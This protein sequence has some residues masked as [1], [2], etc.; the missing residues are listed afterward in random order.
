MSDTV[1]LELKLAQLRAQRTE[2]RA[3]RENRNAVAELQAQVEQEELA[4]RNEQALAEAE[5]QHGPLGD[6]IAA[7]YTRMGVVIVK[8]PVSMVFK[9]FQ[10]AGKTKHEDFDRLV[11]PCLVYPTKAEFD[12]IVEEQP[13]TLIRCADAVAVLAGVQTDDN[14]GKSGR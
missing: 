8:R 6:K 13:A 2:L 10:E 5:E 14:A 11:R 7:V 4:L 9:R 12:R 3:S 1:E